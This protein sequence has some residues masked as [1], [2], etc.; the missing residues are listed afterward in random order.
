VR[1]DKEGALADAAEMARAWADCSRSP[2]YGRP[3]TLGSLKS[4]WERTY[5]WSQ[6]EMWTGHDKTAQEMF[7]GGGGASVPAV[8][9]ERNVALTGAGM[10][11]LKAVPT[12]P[13]LESHPFI[14][15]DHKVRGLYAECNRAIP[16]LDR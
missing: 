7:A 13:R 11:F 3:Y 12:L 1:G 14:R 2:N 10:P 16:A 4:E 5:G 15:E 8:T 6:K 9:G